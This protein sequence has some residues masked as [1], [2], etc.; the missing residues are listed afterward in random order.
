MLP[1]TLTSQRSV[2]SEKAPSIG[3]EGA[4][5][6][7]R[8][9][10]PDAARVP[11][12]LGL[13]GLFVTYV[14]LFLTAWAVLPS[15]VPG[16]RSVVITSGSMAPSIQTGDVVVATPSNGQELMPGTVVL[17]S[18][19]AQPGLITH[20]IIA[21]NA[22]GSYQTGGDANV[23]ADSTP[24]LPEHVIAV[25][26][27]LVPHAGLPLAWYW[28][29]AWLKVAVWGLFVVSSLWVARYAYVPLGRSGWDNDGGA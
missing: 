12:Y 7:P 26:R 19:P 28:D 14:I 20:R 6:V 5:N 8:L 17:I 18:D 23:G 27:L 15:V 16:W 24:V 25:G 1:K 21:V 9:W 10:Q 3:L 11:F 2:G 22:D 4:S 29:G 13:V